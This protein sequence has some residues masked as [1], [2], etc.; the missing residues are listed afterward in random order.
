MVDEI[1]AAVR[2][3]LAVTNY[4]AVLARRGII[5]VALDEAGQIVEYQPDGSS[6]VLRPLPPS[7]D[8]VANQAE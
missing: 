4:G 3:S 7:R 1:D 2:E 8:Q 5:T 6:I